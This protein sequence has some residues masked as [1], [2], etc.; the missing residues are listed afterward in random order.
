MAATYVSKRKP[1]DVVLKT[2]LAGGIAGCCAKSTVAPFDR[3]KILLQAH[4]K[5]YSN[6]GIISTIIKVLN[7]EGVRGLFK[8]NKAQMIRVF[9][10]A[11]TQFSTYEFYKQW[12]RK[13]LGHTQF[14]RLAAGS[15]AGMT[16]V[17]VTYPLDVIRARLAFQVAG[18]VMYAGIIDAFRI[19]IT[20]EGGIRALYKGIVP[21][22]LGMAPYAGLSFYCFEVLKASLLEYFPN[23]CGKPSPHKGDDLV[24][25]VPAK[26]LCGGLAG[27]L[28]QTVS[29]PLDVARRKMQLSLM[30][31]E[32]H[33]FSNWYT[34][35]YVVAKEHGVKNGLYRGLSL[36]YVK[37]TPMVAVSF[38]IYELLKQFFG[39]DTHL[40]R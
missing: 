22:M 18:E 25:L 8:G 34:A 36:N 33:R 2:F 13:N 38:T 40:E 17:L 15:L 28:A 31:P 5:H 29:Y 20:Q 4:H 39:L 21:T 12:L 26:A 6:L 35:L 27:A 23:S 30:L 19:M 24:L 1:G 32:S 37:V 10:Y 3:V 14:S 9:P 16:A 11:A 7:K